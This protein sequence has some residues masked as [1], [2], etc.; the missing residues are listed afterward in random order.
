MLA[1]DCVLQAPHLEVDAL[2]LW[3]ASRLAFSEWV[4]ALH[5]LHGVPVQL[6]HGH[7]DDN[8]G[9]AAGQAL[10]DALAEA[11]ARVRWLAFD[12]G[13]EIPLQAWV[14]LRATVRELAQR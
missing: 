2:A 5:R 13:H 3:A 11:Q 9:F 8:L 14:G 1:L 7:R 4:P 10:R 12:G 6:L